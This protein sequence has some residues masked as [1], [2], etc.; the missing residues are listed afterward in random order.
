MDRGPRQATVNQVHRPRGRQGLPQ[1]ERLAARPEHRRGSRVWSL[2]EAL[3]RATPPALAQQS[4]PLASSRRDNAGTPQGQEGAGERHPK[5][6]GHAKTLDA[7]AM[8]QGQATQGRWCAS[9]TQRSLRHVFS[10]ALAIFLASEERCAR[11][12]SRPGLFRCLTLGFACLPAC[13]RHASDFS[14]ERRQERTGRPRHHVHAR[15]R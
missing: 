5:G 15:R 7:C 12:A 14:A 3:G 11:L 4:P 13:L 10:A 9:G 6:Y 1:Q 8:P 2:P